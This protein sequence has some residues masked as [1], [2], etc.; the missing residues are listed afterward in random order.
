MVHH[1]LDFDL[2]RDAGNREFLAL[3]IRV[4][5]ELHVSTGFAFAFGHEGVH[6][7]RALAVK[8]ELGLRLQFPFALLLV[9]L[10][11]VAVTEPS[12]P[13]ERKDAHK[14]ARA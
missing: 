9:F 13:G 7:P 8:V 11:A 6:F 14:T 1:L 4:R 12:T 2:L 10:F 3:G 5:D